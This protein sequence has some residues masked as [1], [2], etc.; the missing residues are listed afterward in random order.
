MTIS[1]T[2]ILVALDLEQDNRALINRSVAIANK[3]QSRLSF[4]HVDMDFSTVYTG[5]YSLPLQS[6]QQ[7]SREHAFERL[8][9]FA[10]ETPY[11]V[12]HLLVR[13]GKFQ[14]QC[15][16]VVEKHDVDL[17]VCGRHHHHFINKWLSETSLLVNHSTVDVLVVPL[18]EKAEVSVLSTAL[19]S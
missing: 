13:E 11:P 7:Q 5:Y 6:L 10:H 2:H 16:S 9:T 14:E 15:H 17:I 12:T 1:Y 18:Q 8:E 3:Y 19:A 4:L